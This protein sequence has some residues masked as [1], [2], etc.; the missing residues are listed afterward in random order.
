[1]KTDRIQVEQDMEITKTQIRWCRIS[2]GY[3][4]EPLEEHRG[5]EGV[6]KEMEFQYQDRRIFDKER[7]AINMANRR[8]TDMHNNRHVYIPKARPVKEEAELEMRTDIWMKE[9]DK[10]IQEECNMK[11][12]QKE[13]KESEEWIK[14]SS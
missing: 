12:N 7:N 2:T 6:K 14:N 5:E 3:R 8:A 11:G 10:Y 4:Q 1:M 13:D 9:I